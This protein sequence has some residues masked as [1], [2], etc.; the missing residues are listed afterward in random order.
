MSVTFHPA[1]GA[2]LVLKNP[3]WHNI[4][5]IDMAVAINRYMNG[6]VRTYLKGGVAKVL[7]YQWQ[8][9]TKTQAL[10]VATFLNTHAGQTLTLSTF[11]GETWIGKLITD[12]HTI[13][14]LDDYCI[15]GFSLEFEGAISD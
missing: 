11:D 3:M 13:T 1:T 10:A 9:V 15:S 5:D 12:Q 8:A 6:S 7:K 14:N 4:L 2:N